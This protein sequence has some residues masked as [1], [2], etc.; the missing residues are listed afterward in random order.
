[1][2]L[3]EPRRASP[4]ALRAL[5]TA[6]MTAVCALP[7]SARA[8]A[9]EGPGVYG[10]LNGALALGLAFGATALGGGDGRGDTPAFFGQADLFVLSMAGLRLEYGTD[11]RGPVRG[12]PVDLRRHRVAASIELRPLFFY[13]FLTNRFT[14]RE[15]LDTF[16]Y[17]IG[18]EVG[19]SYERR[20]LG[21]ANPMFAGTDGAFGARVGVGFEV[22]LVRR[23][24]HAL[25]LRVFGRV[26]FASDVALPPSLAQL[27]GRTRYNPD[28]FEAGLALRY[29]FHFLD[30]P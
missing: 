24:D 30:R 23:R 4:A 1:M 14:G 7:A 22:P 20:E 2:I 9:R 8:D 27:A 17:S 16:L 29:R 21:S 3:V 13:L 19:A 6:L 10:E 25:L 18:I 28:A 11:V 26:H 15:R 5:F 12:V